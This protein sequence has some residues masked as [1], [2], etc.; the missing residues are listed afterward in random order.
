LTI[1]GGMGGKQAIKRLLEIDPQV[2]GIVSSGYSNDPI[3]ADYKTHGFV[4]VVSKPYRLEEL[5]R[6]LHEVIA[7]ATR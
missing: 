3:M 1:A 2:K 4:G 6:S 5:S 7:E